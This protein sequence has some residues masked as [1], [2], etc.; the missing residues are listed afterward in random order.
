MKTKDT[1]LDRI[2]R[3]NLKPLFPTPKAMMKAPEDQSPL[4]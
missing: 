1:I 2:K 3:N 4:F